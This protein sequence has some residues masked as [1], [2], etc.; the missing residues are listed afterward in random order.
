MHKMHIQKFPLAEI[1]IAKKNMQWKYTV[2]QRLCVR[3]IMW[4]IYRV[5]QFDALSPPFVVIFSFL[6]QS[7]ENLKEKQRVFVV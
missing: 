5:C 3:E 6:F 1:D 7:E 2:D 4:V